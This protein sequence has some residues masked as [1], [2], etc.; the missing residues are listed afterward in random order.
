MSQSDQKLQVAEQKAVLFY[1]D[2][3]TAAH[4]RNDLLTASK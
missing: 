2:E 4:Q 3:I 1:D